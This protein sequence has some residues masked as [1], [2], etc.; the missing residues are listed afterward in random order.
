MKDQ[1][2]LE[3]E[4]P[5]QFFNL[6]TLMIMCGAWT[7]EPRLGLGLQMLRQ[8]MS[9]TPIK[10]DATIV[11]LGPSEPLVMTSFAKALACAATDECPVVFPGKPVVMAF[12]NRSLNTED[13]CSVSKEWADSGAMGWRG[14]IDY[15]LP[16]NVGYVR[17]GM[18]LKDQ[19][20]WK[21]A[22]EGEVVEV[23]MTKNGNMS[24]VVI[25]GSIKLMP[26]DK[27]ATANGIKFTVGEVIPSS[28]M[29]SIIDENT[30]KS[31]KPNVLLS[32]KNVA[33]GLGGQIREIAANTQLFSSIESFRSFSNPEGRQVFTFE[34]QKK[35][36]PTLPKGRVMMKGKV[37]KWKHGTI[38]ASYGIMTI[39]QLRHI[40]TLK[41]H[42]P[43]TA[44]TSITVPRGRYRG[45]TPRLGEAEL[46]SLMMQMVPACVRDS[47]I[48]SDKCIVPVCSICGK[49]IINCDCP[50][51]KPPPRRI[52]VRYGLVVL[53]VFCTVA[54]MNTSDT[55]PIVMRYVTQS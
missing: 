51:P 23:R 37:L 11:S 4:E 45:G 38:R 29:P 16:R 44:F 55:I 13:A 6:A 1:F 43:S 46:M 28:E 19:P 5:E 3:N 10:G 52:Q 54:M 12:I 31:F 21:P 40:A 42:Y 41:H 2:P 50:Q 30:G 22:L 39:L 25:V 35:I 33:R 26:G 20:W 34:D 14:V 15:P 17:V 53:D 48:T 18:V 27:L 36:V 8:A 47:L 24:L 49:L 32:T 9:T 7:M